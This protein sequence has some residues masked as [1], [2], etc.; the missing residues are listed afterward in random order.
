L[1]ASN[2]SSLGGT[3]LILAGSAILLGII[4]GEALFPMPYGTAENAIS[5]LGSTFQPGGEV[6]EPSA[7]IFN[8]TMIVT[9]LMILAGAAALGRAIG[10]RALLVALALLGLFVTLVG[11]FPGTVEGGEPSSEGVHPVVAMLTFVSG[12]V[13][14]ILAGRVTRPPF[15]YISVLLGAIA[16]LSLALAGWLGDTRLGEGGIERW[17]AYPVVLWL[18]A[19]GAYVLGSERAAVED[20]TG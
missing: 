5:D 13:A 17:V 6:R 4:T 12:G 7:T 16:L 20:R 11:I 18:V 14:A 10:S 8:T 15:R 2:R 19:F 1:I 9:G 3:L